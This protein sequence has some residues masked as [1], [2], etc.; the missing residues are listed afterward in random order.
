MTFVVIYNSTSSKKYDEAVRSVFGDK[1]SI[2]AKSSSEL[3]KYL[4]N[5]FFQR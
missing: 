1:E 4:T 5:I 3:G 2:Y